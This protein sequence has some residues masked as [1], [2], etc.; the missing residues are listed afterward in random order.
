MVEWVYYHI[1]ILLFWAGVRPLPTLYQCPEISDT[2]AILPDSLC[3]WVEGI[4]LVI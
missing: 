3:N 2:L 1:P 4:V